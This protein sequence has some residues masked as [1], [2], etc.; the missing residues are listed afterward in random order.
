MSA[1]VVVG[2]EEGEVRSGSSAEAMEEGLV[3]FDYPFYTLCAP[4]HFTPFAHHIN[5]SYFSAEI[6]FQFSF[7]VNNSSFYYLLLLFYIEIIINNSIQ[8]NH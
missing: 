4:H 1:M 8:S 2:K 6:S 3:P 7:L 5:S